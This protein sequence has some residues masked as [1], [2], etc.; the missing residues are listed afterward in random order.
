MSTI[1]TPSPA[2]WNCCEARP[3]G[4]ISFDDG[5]AVLACRPCLGTVSTDR[6]HPLPAAAL[7]ADA[8][9][10][11]EAL[12]DLDVRFLTTDTYCTVS[13]T[14]RNSTYMVIRRPNWIVVVCPDGKTLTADH[15]T[16]ERGMLFAFHNGRRVLRTST[17]QR[18][19]VLE[20]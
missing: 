14:T 18:I 3:A 12:S 6:R 4:V 17:V 10:L 7:L 19:Y 8:V 2:L 20:N 15:V 5:A 16:Y 1:T 11:V 13:V 9:V